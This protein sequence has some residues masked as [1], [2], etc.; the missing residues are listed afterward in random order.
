MAERELILG[1]E[2]AIP[3]NNTAS[4]N[5]LIGTDGSK[6]KWNGNLDSLKLFVQSSL[7]L[8]GKW[9]SPGGSTKQFTSDNVLIK[10]YQ[11]TLTLQF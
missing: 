4:L 2:E 1:A 5:S 10:F 8:T 3:D 6:L 11:N 7:N 9:S